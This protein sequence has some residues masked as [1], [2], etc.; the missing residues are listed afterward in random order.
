MERGWWPYQALGGGLLSPPEHD[1][2]GS[3]YQMT[4]I[5]QLAHRST[6]RVAGTVQESTRTLHIRSK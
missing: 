4:S 2:P 1:A 3:R 5:S 6:L